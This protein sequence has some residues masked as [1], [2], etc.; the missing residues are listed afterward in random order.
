MENEY[1]PPRVPRGL[2]GTKGADLWRSVVEMY[3]LTP[4]E[5][6]ILESACRTQVIIDQLEAGLDG[7]PLTVPGANGRGIQTHPLFESISKQKGLLL[8]QISALK[9]PKPPEEDEGLGELYGI[10][11]ERQR[12][13]TRK[14]SASHAARERWKVHNGATA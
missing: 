7:Q 8:R 11:G 3:E 10:D 5:L 13:M 14:E 2:G 1:T 12:P 6:E 4:V 9:L